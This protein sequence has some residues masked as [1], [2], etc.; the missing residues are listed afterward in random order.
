[1]QISSVPKKGQQVFFNGSKIKI[2]KYEKCKQIIK[3]YCL[4]VAATLNEFLREIDDSNCQGY[5]LMISKFFI[6]NNI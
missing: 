2:L 4:L 6:V 3:E 1:M 5:F